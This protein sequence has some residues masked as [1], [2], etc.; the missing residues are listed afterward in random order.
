M[1]QTIFSVRSNLTSRTRKKHTDDEPSSTLAHLD[2]LEHVLEFSATWNGVETMEFFQ[3]APQVQEYL[4]TREMLR[5]GGFFSKQFVQV[6]KELREIG[7][8][9]PPLLR[10]LFE[11]YY[12]TASLQ[13]DQKPRHFLLQ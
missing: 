1:R 9:Y 10:K 12:L 3:D 13:R 6:S 4:S 2:F 8:E 11:G 5:L 7:V